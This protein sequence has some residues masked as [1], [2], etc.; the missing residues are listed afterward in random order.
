MAPSWCKGVGELEES[1]KHG[2]NVPRLVPVG[3]GMLRAGFISLLLVVST[4]WCDER[5]NNSPRQCFLWHVSFECILIVLFDLVRKSA[6]RPRKIRAIFENSKPEEILKSTDR[7]I[8]HLHLH[9]RHRSPHL[10][11][12]LLVEALN[13]LIILHVL[14]FRSSLIPNYILLRTSHHVLRFLS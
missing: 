2:S 6:G 9:H 3:I 10:I 13:Q 7:R 11:V 5:R 12:D 4:S 1:M 14:A 8:N